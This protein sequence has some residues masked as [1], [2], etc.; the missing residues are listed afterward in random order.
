[1]KILRNGGNFSV[2][3]SRREA[4]P[5]L[6]LSLDHELALLIVSSPERPAM[7][8]GHFGRAPTVPDSTAQPSGLGIKMLPKNSLQGRDST[9]FTGTNAAPSGLSFFIILKPMALP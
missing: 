3:R 4:R 5:K 2:L 1:M 9:G 7:E 8:F 6:P